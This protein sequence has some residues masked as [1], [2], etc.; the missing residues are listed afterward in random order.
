[1]KQVVL[2]L[3]V[4][5]ALLGAAS[6]RPERLRCEYRD[7]PAGIDVTDPRLSWV[8]TPV[9]PKA[10][11]LRQTAYRILVASSVEVLHGNSGNLWDTGK[12]ESD[13]S[14]QIAYGGK[15]LVSGAAAFWKVQVWDQEGHASD[16]SAPAQWSMGLL[17]AEDWQGRWIGRD[18]PGQ[19]HDPSS[20]YRD[21]EHA[22]WIWDAAAAPA[23]GPPADRYFRETFTV[24]EGRKV[25]RAVCIA[26]ADSQ[27]RVLLNG[28]EIAAASNATL[29][30]AADVAHLVRPGTNVVAVRASH[31]RPD[32][33]AGL[34]AAVRVEF[35]SGDPLVI[36]SGSQWRVS[37]KPESGWENPDFLDIAWPAAKELGPYGMPPWG[38]AAYTAE[39][40]LPAR[41]LRKEFA[42]DKKVRRAVVYY[43]G[44]GLSELY[45]NGNKVG[46]HVLSPGLTDYDKRILY[47][48]FDVTGQ[49]VEG[50]N[51]IGLILGNGR[52]YAPRGDG[53][54]RNF[55]FPK[56]LLQLNLEFEDGSRA[57]VVSD[58][59]W[60]LT[61]AGPIRA[62][63]EYD[64]EEYDARM[65]LV[66]WSRPE[67][68]D[69][70][71]EQAVP[72]RA[73][74]GVLAS[75]MAEPLRVT[76]T[77]RPVSVKPLRPGVY[78]FDMGQNM[79]GWCRL[80][81]SARRARR[82]GCDTQRR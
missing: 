20:P 71:W 79:V 29:P 22:K 57:S 75:Q 7:N 46:D 15:P 52:F 76:E 65:D 39:H 4:A 62:N 30:F 56:G 38:S 35:D 19:F 14:I 6:V 37:V 9:N 5:T 33:P 66:G 49:V 63:N 11:G 41:F 58:T 28:T 3:S 72:V 59:T 69:A 64:G 26:G 81:V 17:R 70:G 16:W 42:V 77:I 68:D 34:I 55:G 47:E 25:L 10:R 12:V 80:R 13:Q 73:P 54:A 53:S 23:G 40:R 61:A 45:L 67:F 18:E 48:T 2:I 8:L 51:A 74:A 27:A 60:K 43:A 21:L 31:T 36:L 1:M 24:A 50:R 82:C 78:I 44:L 32:R